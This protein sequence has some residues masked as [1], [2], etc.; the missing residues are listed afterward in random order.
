MP[1]KETVYEND[2]LRRF[3]KDKEHAKKLGSSS[4]QK[5]LWVCPNCKTQLVKSPGEIKRRGFKCKVC[6]DNRSYSE[7]LMEQLLKDNNIFYISQM[8]FDNC[9]YKDVLPFDFYL[10][11]ENICIEMHGEQ[12][13]DVRKNSKWYNDRM[14]FSDKI[15]EEYCLKNEM[16][17]VAINC[18]KSDIDY[19]LKEIKNSKLSDILNVYDK[20]SL[21]NAVMTR[22]LNV[23]VKYLIDQHK[24]GI[25]F[26]EISRETGLYRK[27]IVSILKKLGEYNPRGGAK[28][29]TR[30]VVRLNDNKIFGSIKEAIDEVDLKQENNIVMVCRGKRKYAG[31]NPK[32]GEKYR[33]AYYSDYI[34]K[35]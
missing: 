9:V 10:P 18:S 11:K 33:W 35:S 24:K 17:Y 7:R 26:L 28:N 27:K 5:I 1:I 16:D 22:I 19:I 6:A 8:R 30:K 23:D 31:R 25:S 4:T 2:Y 15:K 13:Y 32:T 29:N 3:V 34:E 12:H 21:K 14:L 20:N